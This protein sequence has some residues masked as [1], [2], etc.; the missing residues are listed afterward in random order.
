MLL[1]FGACLALAAAQIDIGNLPSAGHCNL[2]TLSARVSALQAR[3]C[4]AGEGG[5]GGGGCAGTIACASAL[6]PLL[7]DCRPTLDIM[8]DMNDGVRDGTAAQLDDLNAQCLA[9]PSAEVLTELKSMHDAG[10]CSNELLDGVARTDVGTAPCVDTNEHCDILIVAGYSCQDKPLDDDCRAS[11]GVCDENGAGVGH[12]LQI[13][14][15][16]PLADFETQAAAVNDACCDDNVCGGVPTVCDA[17]CAVVFDDFFDRCSSILGLQMPDHM[18]GFTRL[19]TTC[20]SQ[21]P[22]EPLLRAVIDCGTQARLVA[23]NANDFSSWDAMQAA[24]WTWDDGGDEESNGCCFPRAS[25][26]GT[27]GAHDTLQDCGKSF[28]NWAA[29]GNTGTLSLVLPVTGSGLVDF[30]DCAQGNVVLAINGAQIAAARAGAGSIVGNIKFTAGDVLT[31]QDVSVG[32]GGAIIQ[33]NSI[34][35]YTCQTWPHDMTFDRNAQCSDNGW[36]CTNPSSEAI[37]SWDGDTTGLCSYLCEHQ[38]GCVGF[39]AYDLNHDDPGRCCL[40]SSW[41]RGG[42]GCVPRSRQRNEGGS[43]CTMPQPQCFFEEGVEYPGDDLAPA[44]FADNYA[45]CP[46]VATAQECCNICA[47]LPGCL[48]FT[49][50]DLNSPDLQHASTWVWTAPVC[51]LKSV[52]YPSGRQVRAGMISGRP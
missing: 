5:G 28:F 52:Q 25:S 27:R 18:S 10:T 4:S 44:Q 1:V 50:V 41:E 34:Y 17:K 7:D 29:S 26:K 40:K 8:L 42:A 31:L 49:W 51:C 24:G 19:H 39:F 47:G 12:R 23:I 21:L 20:S 43:F 46:Y 45:S 36:G 9:I 33:L 30:G 6:L 16:C 15:S 11:C 48:S 13:M 38:P 3:C 37:H 32:S 35:I 14:S 22:V 2:A